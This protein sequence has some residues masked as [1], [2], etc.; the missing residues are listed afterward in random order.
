MNKKRTFNETKKNIKEAFI[1]LYFERDI[2]NITV[3]DVCNEV[4]ISR[5]NFI[6]I[7]IMCIPCMKT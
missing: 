5:Q 1:R 4:P 3:K 6:I 2:T 7:M